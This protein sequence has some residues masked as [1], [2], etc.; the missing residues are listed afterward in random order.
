M[1][2]NH[3]SYSTTGAEDE[4]ISPA[5]DFSNDTLINLEFEYASAYYSSGYK[6]SLKVYVSDDCGSTWDLVAAYDGSD[7][8]YTTA[9]AVTSAF[10]PSDSTY[11]CH[12]SSSV[13]CPTIDLDAY[14]GTAG[15][16]V[17][18][19]AVNGYGNNI[20]LDNINISGQ[21]QFPPVAAFTG[22]T[23]GC[24]GKT[25]QFYDY[26]APAAASRL[27]SFQGGTPSTSSSAN[28]SVTY[29]TP[30]MYDVKLVVAN[31]AGIDS[32]VLSNY[33]TIIS[34]PS[35]GIALSTSGPSILC[36]G[37]SATFMA[38]PTNGGLNPTINW[39]LNGSVVASNSFTY[40]GTFAN[41]DVLKVQ[42][43]SSDDCVA[44]PVVE[45]SITLMVNS[46]PAVTLGSQGYVCELDGPQLLSGGQPLGGI[47]SGSG[48]VNDSIYPSTSGVGSHWVYYTYTDPT[49]G[50][51]R[52][53][54]RAISV[55]PAP[56]KPTVSQN[57]MGELEAAT[58]AGTFT[59]EWLDAS[60]NPISGATGATFLPQSNGDYYVR[61]LSN[62]LCS[63]VSDAYSVV[64]IGL[65]EAMTTGW[66]VYPNPAQ[67]IVTLRVEGAA[68]VRLLDASGRLVY[69][70]RISG[71]AQL[72]V[73]N[74][75]RG[76]YVLQVI[77]ATG[78]ENEAIVLQ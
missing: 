28:P 38:T 52:T 48:I 43:I 75:A 6:D 70:G 36:N 23:A 35:A 68:D 24:T 63:N 69:S 49:T 45:D 50:C 14:S 9:G 71:E 25:L 66:S 3:Y 59:Y 27:W 7:A 62:I 30:G 40:G 44:N 74:W 58:P 37:D 12:G 17:K 4:L 78:V 61:I 41:N 39:I 32:V 31:A 16:R 5:L 21:A 10:A 1:T 77:T 65:D 47:Y 33:V 19:V 54:Q 73:Q 60:M 55:Q 22:D 26:T 56:G 42:M 20:Y 46:L 15:V 51:S 2:I 11:W 64:N 13:T 72:D 67:K 18:F 34:A 29:A 8:S 76:T 57:T 53:K